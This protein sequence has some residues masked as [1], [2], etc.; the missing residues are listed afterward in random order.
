MFQ[1]LLCERGSKDA[2]NVRGSADRETHIDLQ[3]LVDIVIHDQAMR[4]PDTMRLHRMA[5]DVGI[6]ADIRVVEV[7]DS[8]LVHAHRAVERMGAVDSRG[9]GHLRTGMRQRARKSMVGRIL[10]R[11]KSRN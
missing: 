1:A 2:R 8:F 9:I 6:I 4:Q 7:G 5:G 3:K 10:K 11:E